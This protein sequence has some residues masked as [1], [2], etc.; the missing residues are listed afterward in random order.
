MRGDEIR[1]P[2][3]GKDVTNKVLGGLPGMQKEGVDG[4]IIDAVFTLHDQPKYSRVLALEFF[5]RSMKPAAELINKIV[6]LRNR[7]RNEGDYVRV[8]A[9][10]EFNVKYV[11]A[12]EYKRKSPET[13][14]IPFPSSSCRSTATTK[15]FLM[16]A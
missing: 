15:C 9:L 12:I 5:G 1:L 16:K 3:L 2:G 13:R 6:E 7:I 4:L 10:E 14:A 11:Q 8:S